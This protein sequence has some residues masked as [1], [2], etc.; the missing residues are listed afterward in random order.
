WFYREEL[1]KVDRGMSITLIPK[2]IRRRMIRLG[3]LECRRGLDQASGFI[4]SPRGRK[5]LD[6]YKNAHALEGEEG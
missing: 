3:I 4:L 2:L 1:M 5:I 6:D